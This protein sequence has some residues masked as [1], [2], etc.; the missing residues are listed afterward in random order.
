M[1]TYKAQSTEITIDDE[2]LTIIRK[3]IGKDE[4]RR[5]PLA[6][7]TDLRV[8]PGGRFAPALLQLV[9]NDEPPAT[10]KPTEPNTFLFPKTPKHTTSFNALQARLEAA[11]AH[12]RTTSTPHVPYDAPS[13]PTSQRL[14]DSAR[15]RSARQ[16]EAAARAREE[17]VARATA[18]AQEA[19]AAEQA[20]I[21]QLR[22]DLAAQGITRED[23]VTA[24]LATTWLGTTASEIPALARTLRPDEPLLHATRATFNDH[25]GM[26]ALT[27]TRFIALDESFYSTEATEFPLT[28]VITVT[29][30]QEL[31][32]NTLTVTLHN[33]QTATY[34]NVQDLQTFTETLKTATRHTP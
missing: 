29:Q 12:N 3:K 14:L 16:A 8:D 28:A 25:V 27:P 19:E 26:I 10:M 34:T 21:A 2:V 30:Q 15:E 1:D 32:S 7:I 17:S 9:L 4:V 33:G 24:A 18:A 20:R 13:K 11:V 6:A 23:V 31:L 22:A 5:I